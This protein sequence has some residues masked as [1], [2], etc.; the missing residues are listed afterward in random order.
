M[1]LDLGCLAGHAMISQWHGEL[2]E[3]ALHG[4]YMAAPFD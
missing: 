4:A 1:E 2:M 3:R